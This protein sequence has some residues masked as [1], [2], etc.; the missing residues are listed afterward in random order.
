[1][2]ST[3]EELNIKGVRKSHIRGM[4]VRML[5]LALQYGCTTSSVRWTPIS[6]SPVA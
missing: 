3:D 2:E 1:M 4:M 6:P 5:G